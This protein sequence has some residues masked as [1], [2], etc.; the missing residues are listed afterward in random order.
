MMRTFF[1]ASLLISVVIFSG[2]TTTNAVDTFLQ[3]YPEVQDFINEHPNTTIT[4]VYL[5]E[6]VV[7]SRIGSIRSDCGDQMEVLPY[8]FITV[9][10]PANGNKYIIEA[11]LNS[12]EDEI[13]C[14]L[15]KITYA[16]G[17]TI[18]S[19][20][21]EVGVPATSGYGSTNAAGIVKLDIMGKEY[22]FRFI[23]ESDGLPISGL[24]LSYELNENKTAGVI[25]AI[26]PVDPKYRGVPPQIIVLKGSEETSP[27][28]AGISG[29][30]LLDAEDSNNE[31][32]D[33][34]VAEKG[35]SIIK[36]ITIEKLKKLA[37]PL[38]DIGSLTVLAA[39]VL[40]QSGLDL[41]FYSGKLGNA[42][43][44]TITVEE[45][46]EEVTVKKRIGEK[47]TFAN[48]EEAIET[49]GKSLELKPS[50]LM[51]DLLH[52]VAD[53]NAV[54]V[55]GLP[56]EKVQVTEIEGLPAIYS[57]KQTYIGDYIPMQIAA[58]ANGIDERGLPLDPTKSSLSLVSKGDLGLAYDVK[59]DSGG[60]AIAEVPK[61]SYLAKISS[62]GFAPAYKDMDEDNSDFDATLEAVKM[63]VEPGE[64]LLFFIQNL[65]SATKGRNYIYSL[66]KPDLSS[67]YAVC[68]NNGDTDNPIGGNPPYSFRLYEEDAPPSGITLY[69][70]GMMTGV[71]TASAGTYCFGVEVVDQLYENGV[72]EACIEVT[73]PQT[74]HPP[75]GRGQCSGAANSNKC[76]A[77]NSNSDCG[78]SNC[79][80]SML[81][82]PFC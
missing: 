76:G 32:N 59:F 56:N 6:N 64:E 41:G 2:C 46:R 69:Q 77:C 73:E 13:F 17:T 78:G 35:A 15:N 43:Q 75:S 65:P 1:L 47:I 34:F 81:P 9:T 30:L 54:S 79:Y 4:A 74:P 50:D 44:K 80:T 82:A 68:G 12:D 70:N 55:C 27:Q 52:F 60:S 57:C 16:N 33:V 10:N 37:G 36:E 7:A 62:P 3:N 23:N 39:K 20:P 40:D 31:I 22:K 71:V 19:S 49:G 45:A 18:I 8:Y 14:I 51:L 38:P 61:G 72:I 42:K 26:D 53:K 67:V 21:N 5:D 48:T 25:L 58:N 63:P 24:Y 28:S 11:Y 29:N 66:C